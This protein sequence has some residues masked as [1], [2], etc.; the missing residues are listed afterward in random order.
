MKETKLR[1]VEQSTT[2]VLNKERFLVDV[3]AVS[4]DHGWMR[5]IRGF[6]AELSQIP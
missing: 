1:N 5:E 6:Q 2:G 4:T 3:K